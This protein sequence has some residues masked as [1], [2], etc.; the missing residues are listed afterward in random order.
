MSIKNKE[1]VENSVKDKVKKLEVSVDEKT[2][3]QACEKS[4]RKNCKNIRVPGF[5]VGKAP[6]KVV[7]KLYGAEIFYEDAIK[8]VY[9]KSLDDAIEKSKLDVVAVDE[10]FAP[11]PANSQPCGAVPPNVAYV[12]KAF[13]VPYV[14]LDVALNA[15]HDEPPQY[16]T[17]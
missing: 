7:E 15:V 9:K 17:V 6:K 10:F 13:A 3:K 12:V 8:F 1:N 16:F 4:Y 2:F 11:H 5:R 14:W